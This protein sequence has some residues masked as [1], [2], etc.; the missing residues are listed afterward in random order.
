MHVNNRTDL[1]KNHIPFCSNFQLCH[2]PLTNTGASKESKSKNCCPGS[3]SAQDKLIYRGSTHIVVQVTMNFTIGGLKPDGSWKCKVYLHK[4]TFL[5]LGTLTFHTKRTLNKDY[6]RL[7]DETGFQM[8][9]TWTC[10]VLCG[11][12][13]RILK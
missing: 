12:V 13:L 2:I 3:E 5:S 4:T 8:I 11:L 9:A 10:N 6:P 7:P 1:I